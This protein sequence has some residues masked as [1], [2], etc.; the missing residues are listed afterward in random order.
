[1]PNFSSILQILLLV[2][3][4]T[5]SHS[6]LAN[7]KEFDINE[8]STLVD[9]NQLRWK[10]RIIIIKTDDKTDSASISEKKQDS[11]TLIDKKAGIDDRDIVWLLLNTSTNESV[12][13]NS[14]LNLS[15]NLQGQ[16]LDLLSKH[17]KSRI[18]LIGKDG[19]IK[20][21]SKSLDLNDIFNQIDAM[22]MRIRE[23]QKN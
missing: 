6:N 23:M 11:N 16:L 7:S 13:S 20:S 22:P 8:Q 21:H 12:I 2:S 14:R 17:P 3:S 10:N 9:I 18:I 15:K 4:V 5:L 1:V 19:G